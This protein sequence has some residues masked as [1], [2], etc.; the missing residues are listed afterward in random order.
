[1]Q[2]PK[3]SRGGLLDYIGAAQKAAPDLPNSPERAVWE[4][5]PGLTELEIRP[6]FWRDT[7]FDYL[8][9][10][11]PAMTHA[12]LAAAMAHLSDPHP[13]DVVWDPFCGAGTELAERARAGAYTQLIGSD[14][15]EGALDAARE[16]LAGVPQVHLFQGD[17][18]VWPDFPINVLL[19]NPPYGKKVQGGNA[20]R[21]LRVLLEN[22]SRNMR[23]GRI[24]LCSPMPKETWDFLR[25]LGWSAVSTMQVGTQG[26]A[27]EAQL[28]IRR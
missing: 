10:E 17:A 1:L 8:Q 21:A 16:N 20:A 6:R 3:L 25:R 11:I 23:T 26:K 14:R 27:I 12:P 5:R 13:A 4:F 7:R 19:T 24:V 9:A 22:A 15:E 28:F 2:D 18:G